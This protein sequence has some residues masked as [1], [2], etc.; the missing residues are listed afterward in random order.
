MTDLT[1]KALGQSLKSLLKKK[2]LDKITIKDIVSDCGVNRQTFYYHFQDIYDLL[3]WIFIV[4]ATKEMEQR[5]KKNETWQQG[6]LRTFDYIECNKSF[7]I[8]TYNSI[9]REHFEKYI[10]KVIR[11]LLA[12]V[13][14][15]RSEGINVTYEDKNFII[16]FYT[17]AL[18][19]VIL[20]WLRQGTQENPKKIVDKLS[21]LIKGD[22]TRA[23][24][25]FDKN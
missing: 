21:K 2:T 22:V 14:E 9:G 20:N 5:R 11:Q 18:L 10:N 23:L 8:N 6:L 7:V 12:E 13:V 24:E 16:D 1:K 3:D 25:K 19:G 17:Y 15:Q 4:E